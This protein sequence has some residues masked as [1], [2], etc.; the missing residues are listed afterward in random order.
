M[1]M[2][3][4]L[5]ENEQC[6]LLLLRNFDFL[7]SQGY[8]IKEFSPYG[9]W[10]Y[11]RYENKRIRQSVSMEWDPTNYLLIEIS[12]TSLFHGD[13]FALKD[14]YRYFDKNMCDL[15][16]PPMYIYMSEIIEINVNLIQQ[17][18][19]PII[20]GEIWIDKLIKQKQSAS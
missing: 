19:M 8:N 16:C 6:F 9:R 13:T 3:V 4:E 2:S 12:R 18:L 20:K 10:H 7:R 14:I 5:K 11:L 1:I 15:V 17:H